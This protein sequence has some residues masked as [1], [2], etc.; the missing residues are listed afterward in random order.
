[1]ELLWSVLTAYV[2]F[3]FLFQGIGSINS[4][5]HT[6][7]DCVKSVLDPACCWRSETPVVLAFILLSFSLLD[8]ASFS[9]WRALLTLNFVVGGHTGASGGERGAG[10]A[11]RVALESRRRRVQLPRA[12]PTT[13]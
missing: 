2:V 1:M 8:L 13:L 12:W 10:V 9:A 5:T 6:Q 4:P 7:K 11:G 3:S